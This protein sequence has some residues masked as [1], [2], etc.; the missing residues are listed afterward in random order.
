[1]DKADTRNDGSFV[2]LAVEPGKVGDVTIS[3]A[4]FFLKLKQADRA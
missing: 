3:D 4:K 1:V 2:Y